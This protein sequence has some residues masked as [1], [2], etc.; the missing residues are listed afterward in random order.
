[1]S[2]QSEQVNELT[3][4]LVQAQLAMPN[5]LKDSRGNYGTY[6]TI[7][8]LLDAVKKPLGENGIAI[9]QAPMPTDGTTIC[10]R[11]MLL[12]KSGQWIASEL[13]RGRR[14]FGLEGA[15]ETC[16]SSLSK[17]GRV[18]DLPKIFVSR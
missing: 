11:T 12:H 16:L 2:Y 3:A 10:L 8:S 9:V 4:A 6:T 15:P 5:A 17:K 18:C 1:M 14:L 13:A 7:T